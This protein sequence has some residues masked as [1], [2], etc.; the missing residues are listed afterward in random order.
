[1]DFSLKSFASVFLFTK[2]DWFIKAYIALLIIAPVLNVFVEH[3]SRSRLKITLILF[4]LFQSIYGWSGSAVWFEQG[5]SAFSFIGLYLLARYIYIFRPYRHFM[6]K[7]PAIAI[8]FFSAF[9]CSV[10]AYL[11][12]RYNIMAI[13]GFM[14]TYANP[15]VILGSVAM[16][17]SF[18]S[19]TIQNDIIN[20]MAKSTFAVYLFPCYFIFD[21]AYKYLIF[22]IYNIYNGLT[23]IG[24]ICAILIIIF[25]VSIAF[26]QIRIFIWNGIWPP[27][28]KLINK[29]IQKIYI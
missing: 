18:S 16:L 23:V 4:F 28:E 11:G 2:S 7:Y 22:D 12:C 26:D 5:Y 15:F 10:M 20:K 24:L 13:P 3:A 25:I 17:Y 21:F 8:Y 6:Y 9:L 29:S 14:M 19:L 27:I 1:M